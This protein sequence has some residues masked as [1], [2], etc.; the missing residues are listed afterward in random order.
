MGTKR[1]WK[2]TSWTSKKR[3]LVSIL[4]TNDDDDSFDD[5]VDDDVDRRGGHKP[6]GPVIRDFSIKLTKKTLAQGMMIALSAKLLEGNF[7]VV[8]QMKTQVSQPIIIIIPITIII[9]T[10][11]PIIVN[12]NKRSLQ[13]VKGK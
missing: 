3:H 11:I 10:I 9:T 12:Q 6:H 7:V 1:K 13:Y 2:S 4:R 5:A 8:D